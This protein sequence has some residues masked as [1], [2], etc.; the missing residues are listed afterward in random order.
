MNLLQMK[1]DT[2][3]ANVYGTYVHGL[4]DRKEVSAGILKAVADE[5]QKV[6]DTRSASDMADIKEAQYDMLADTLRASLD[7]DAI[8]KMMG[9]EHD[10]G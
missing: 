5:R 1:Q 7:I 4:F 9:I 6:V 10:N 2:V 3:V 8:Y